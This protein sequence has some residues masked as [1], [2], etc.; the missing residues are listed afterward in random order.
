M[1]LLERLAALDRLL[2][3]KGWPATSGWWQNTIET[4]YNSGKPFL[5]LRVGRRGGKSSTLCRVAVAEALWGEHD[6]P[7]GDV[8]VVPFVSTRLEEAGERLQTIRK[9]LVAL[10]VKFQSSSDALRAQRPDGKDVM[11]R[12]FPATVAGVSGF[13]TICGVGDEVAKWKDRDTGANPATEVLRALRP[14]LASQPN[15]KLILSSSPLGLLDAHADAFALGDTAEQM[16]A[17][18]ETWVANPTLSIERTKQ[19]EPDEATW[20]R[21]YAAIP[22]AEAES[23]FLSEVSVDSCTRPAPLHIHRE[24]GVSYYATMD[25]ATRGHA[26]TFT[27][28]GI[29]P[30]MKKSVVFH[31]EWQGTRD[32]PLRPRDVLRGIRSICSEY[33]VDMVWTDQLA[34]DALRDIADDLDL[35]LVEAPWTLGRKIEAFESLRADLAANNVEL[36]P[37]PVMKTDLL[38]VKKRLTRSGISLEIPEI[39]GRHCDYAPAVAMLLHLPLPLPDLTFQTDLKGEAKEKEERRKALEEEQRKTW[40]NRFPRSRTWSSP[41]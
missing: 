40:A 14:T 17:M 4:F 2:V 26:W 18:A 13:T 5:V 22:Q 33:G 31:K 16:V 29:R 38:Q 35:T 8:G 10:G 7:P 27:V 12:C 36:P 20:R 15:A 3:S 41:R 11:W 24:R 39:N 6:I 28:G 23:S 9:I 32:S 19:L 21:E 37:D 1:V 25:P 30:N 34:V